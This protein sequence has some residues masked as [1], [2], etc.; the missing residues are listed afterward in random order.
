[1]LTKKYKMKKRFTLALFLLSVIQL[2]AQEVH[3]ATANLERLK[4]KTGTMILYY[5]NNRLVG[6]CSLFT[7]DFNKDDNQDQIA[8]KLKARVAGTLPYMYYE[9]KEGFDC[10]NAK[11][12]LLKKGV[13]SMNISSCI[14]VSF[15]TNSGGSVAQPGTNYWDNPANESEKVVMKLP[16]YSWLLVNKVVEKRVKEL[17][18]AG[19]EKVYTEFNLAGGPKTLWAGKPLSF[20][21][22]YM[23]KAI[24]NVQRSD[25]IMKLS[26]FDKPFQDGA[27]Q[28]ELYYEFKA[29]S[30][31]ETRLF[32]SPIPVKKIVF[33]TMSLDAVNTNNAGIIIFRKKYNLRDEFQSILDDAK[34]DFADFKGSETTDPNG[35]VVYNAPNV[36]GL[37]K[38]MVFQAPSSREW[39]FSQFCDADDAYAA[40]IKSSIQELISSYVATGRYKTESGTH[41]GAMVYRL[42]A[43]D[44]EILFQLAVG[45][46]KISLNF[47]A[48]D[49]KQITATVTTKP[50]TEIRATNNSGPVK[51]TKPVA[52]LPFIDPNVKYVF[53][54]FN[55]AK[56]TFKWNWL[57]TPET[58]E[59]VYRRLSDEVLTIDHRASDYTWAVAEPTVKTG[60]DYT[61]SMLVSMVKQEH[62]DAAQGIIIRYRDGKKGQPCN[63]F[64]MVN[65]MQQ[66][67]WF[68]SNNPNNNEWKTYNKFTGNIYDVKSTAINEHVAGKPTDNLLSVKK[69]GN[70]FYL[71][72]NKQLVEEV[73]I[74]K[75]DQA[76]TNFA[77]I[78]IVTNHRQQ[79]AIR[80]ISFSE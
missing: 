18:A 22:D 19:W 34:N 64:F 29:D 68:G 37:K 56:I 48:T 42:K 58:D 28:D 57:E 27:A 45:P 32:H 50:D 15:K 79:A 7:V 1:M 25:F 14:D 67:Y 3:V 47:F 39:M 75:K 55:W 21:P 76:L 30:L 41:E 6:Y 10:A 12:Y 23:Y 59:N 49:K 9:F 52:E 60:D 16:T 13:S 72:I 40:T 78:G 69:S 73:E 35:V 65:P 77:G 38:Q 31:G 20:E 62:Q 44:D 66:R 2:T 70:K 63:L 71:Y 43:L 17:E 11:S 26:N 80:K 4:Y 61:Y 54:N 33:A 5:G 74:G 36:L 46:K 51:D 8:E 53:Q 24:G